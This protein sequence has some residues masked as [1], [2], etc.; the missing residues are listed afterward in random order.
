MP[1]VYDVGGDGKIIDTDFVNKDLSMKLK[2]LRDANM[3]QWAALIAN[4]DGR[5]MESID[6]FRRNIAMC[7]AVLMEHG[8]KMEIPKKERTPEDVLKESMGELGMM[9][10]SKA[11]AQGLNFYRRVKEDIMDVNST[12]E[13]ADDEE[14]EIFEDDDGYY[15]IDER[16]NE[17]ACDVDGTPLE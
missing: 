5:A 14:F 3:Q 11:F 10:G 7:A 2:D 17:I 12:Y 15:Y 16:G 4:P 1:D 8:V 9:L 13:E 6:E